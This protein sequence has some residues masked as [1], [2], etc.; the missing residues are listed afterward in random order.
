MG[1]VENFKVYHVAV[2]LLSG[3]LALINTLSFCALQCRREVDKMVVVVT[4][5][6]HTQ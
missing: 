2:T 4:G 1:N 5:H 6:L 3:T